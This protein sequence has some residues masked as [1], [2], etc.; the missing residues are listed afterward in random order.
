MPWSPQPAL[1]AGGIL[2][3]VTLVAVVGFLASWDVLR[4]RPLG[5]LRA[6]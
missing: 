3:S 1:V 4:R 5:T 6:E 2:G